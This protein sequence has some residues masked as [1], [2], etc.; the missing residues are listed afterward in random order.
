MVRLN[1]VLERSELATTSPLPRYSLQVKFAA[2]F[3]PDLQDE[4]LDRAILDWQN[5]FLSATALARIALSK[6]LVTSQSDGVLVHL[7]NGETRKLASGPSSELAKAVVEEFTKNFMKEPAVVLMSESA[8]K[9]LLKDDELCRAIGFNVNVST[10]LPDLILA[11]LGE[12]KPIIVFVECVATDGPINDRRKQELIEL[13]K[14]A[15]YKETDCAYVTVFKDRADRESRKLVPSIAWNTFI[16]YAS[17]P[18]EIVFLRKG[19][20]EKRVSI[21]E[22][23]KL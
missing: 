2:L 10:V 4:A 7:P 22:M 11:E 1:A 18:D 6:R 9:L 12:E 13:A 16:W 17:E 3:N 5:E 21:G 23:L 15:N 14:L 20:I 8:K 19:G